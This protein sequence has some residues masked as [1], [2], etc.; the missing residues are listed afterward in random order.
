MYLLPCKYLIKNNQIV[1]KK[2]KIK[3]IT[4]IMF[5]LYLIIK[6]KFIITCFIFNLIQFTMLFTLL[7]NNPKVI[8]Q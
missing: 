6:P 7:L 8:S 5:I 3:L 2:K 1:N 4:I